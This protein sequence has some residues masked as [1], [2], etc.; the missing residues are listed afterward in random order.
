MLEIEEVY[1]VTKGDYSDYSIYGVFLD[2]ELAE[3]FAAQIS[4]DSDSGYVRT[5][6]IKKELSFPK[7][8][9]GYR[10]EMDIE[11]NSTVYLEEM[12]ENL[13]NNSYEE[14]GFTNYPVDESW[15]KTGIYNFYVLTDKGKEGAI[16]IANERR[17]QMIAENRF[18][19]KGEVVKD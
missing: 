12:R 8:F 18:P 2:K 14:I 7:G 3:E 15:T 4:N 5:D 19:I 10:V 16:K 1:I 13:E 6:K 11:G 17:I 9:R